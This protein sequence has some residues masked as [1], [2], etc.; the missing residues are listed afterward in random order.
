MEKIHKKKKKV[1]KKKIKK[2]NKLN[3][4]NKE[5]IKGYSVNKF[6]NGD[7][8]LGYAINNS[9]NN[10]GLYYYNS[11][12]A[13][14]YYLGQ[15]QNNLRHGFGVYLSHE[16]FQNF[17]KSKFKAFIGKFVE[18]KFDK[19]TLISKQ[20]D[21]YHLFHG[22]FNNNSKCFYYSANL[23]KLLYGYFEGN[24]FIK[25]YVSIFN[26]DGII[27]EF[28]KYNFSENNSDDDIDKIKNIMS[29]FRNCVM[30]KDY[31]G[32]FFEIFKIV[33]EFK[34]IFLNKDINEI[35]Y[36]YEDFIDICKSYKKFTIFNDIER[37]CNI[38]NI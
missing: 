8:Y 20:G 12:F 22:E 2:E 4:F 14:K 35:N 13:P 19:G 1:K 15:W 38:E 6:P 28:R 24:K 10:N 32:D 23:E 11:I 30:M 37:V 25:G 9:R 36:K 26:D 27:K 34:D 7:I 16:N 5:E 29:N 31:F 3:I 17:E 21:N 33:I 18:D